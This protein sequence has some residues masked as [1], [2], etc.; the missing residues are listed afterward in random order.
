MKA[1]PLL[2]RAQPR[3]EIERNSKPIDL[4]YFIL[5]LVSDELNYIPFFATD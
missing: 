2:F 3:R 1:I 4:Q 5:D